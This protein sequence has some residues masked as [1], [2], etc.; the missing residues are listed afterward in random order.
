MIKTINGWR[1]VFALIIVLFHAGV[2]GMTLMPAGVVFFLM[3]SG[4][5][6]ELK[7]PFGQLDKHAYRRFALRSAAKLYPLHWLALALLLAVLALVGGLVIDPVSLPLNAALLQSW[8]LYHHIC[9]SYNSFS[10]F[11]S[12]LLFCYLCFP[13]LSRWFMPLRVMHQLV[14]VGAMSLVCLIV[15]LITDEY[16]F[17]VTTVFPP[18]RIIEFMIGMMLVKLLPV[19]RQVKL[20]NDRETGIDIELASVALLSGVALVFIAHKQTL[21]RV[22][23]SFLWWIPVAV[24]L[25]VCVIYDRREG[26]VGKLLASRPMQWLGGLCFELFMLQRVAALAFGYLVAPVLSHLGMGHPSPFAAHDAF[27][28]GAVSPYS[29]LP[30]FIIPIDIVL[31][32]AVNRLFTRPLRRYLSSRI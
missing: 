9:F 23:E 19:L 18:V 17:A 14:I 12:T 27:D 13:L 22:S 1:A 29:L 20:F 2:K 6:M 21:Y 25:L 26:I 8:S 32:W 4:F 24:I 31:A 30:W 11:L 28:L 5:L 3:A 16:G 7:H 10:W 15:M